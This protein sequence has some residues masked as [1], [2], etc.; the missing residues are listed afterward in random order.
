MSF[1]INYTTQYFENLDRSGWLILAFLIAIF[2]VIFFSVWFSNYME[3]RRFY[4][5]QERKAIL[6][7]SQTFL[8]CNQTI[9][10]LPTNNVN[11]TNA[12]W[13]HHAVIYQIMIDRFY[14]ANNT[15]KIESSEGFDKFYGGNIKGISDK[16][17]YIKKQGYN[18]I[19]LSPIFQSNAYHG[20]HTTDFS[21]IDPHFG[22]WKDFLELINDIHDCGMKI[23]CDYVPNHCH[24]ENYLFQDAINNR[25]DKRDWFYFKGGTSEYISFLHYDNLPKFNLRNKDAAEY[26]I[27]VAEGLVHA[28]VDGLRID[29]VIGLP[30]D[31]LEELMRR[32]KRINPEVFVFGE[33]TAMNIQKESISQLEIKSDSL[34]M[35]IAEQNYNQDELQLQYVNVIDGILDFEY[36][37][38]ILSEKEHGFSGNQQLSQKLEKHF[39]NFPSNFTPVLFLDNHDTNRIMFDCKN[40]M[41]LVDEAL[42]FTQNQNH[43]VCVYYGTEQYMTHDKSINESDSDPY[44]DLQCR[45]PMDW[46]YK[47]VET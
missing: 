43:P 33:A 15:P 8:S 16:L 13:W 6:S 18:A 31:F 3:V 40:D 14:K 21:S 9:H 19:M 5:E 22:N 38:I 27:H 2:C 11:K 44:S 25:N 36:R 39:K 41:D 35:A 34:K 4:H 45:N 10:S 17:N 42:V 46:G 32:V 26:M 28:G 37:N 24:K 7:C 47:K 1:L 30:F 29:H 12:R 23:I 20:Y